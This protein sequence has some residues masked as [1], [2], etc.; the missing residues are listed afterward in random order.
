M[1]RTILNAILNQM[2]IWL[3]ETEK[4]QLHHELTAYFGLIGAAGE[5]EALENV[6]KHPYNRREMKREAKT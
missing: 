3:N 6:W 4:E 1:S 2:Q 5:C